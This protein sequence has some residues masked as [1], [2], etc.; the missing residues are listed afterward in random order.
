M[1]ITPTVQQ[2]MAAEG[3][4]EQAG[5]AAAALTKYLLHKAMS[6]QTSSASLVAST[7]AVAQVVRENDLITRRKP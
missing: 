2:A 4:N 6:C 7:P 3:E 5:A 1:V